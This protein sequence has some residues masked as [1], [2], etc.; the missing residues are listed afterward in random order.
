MSPK[1]KKKQSAE[2]IIVLVL[3]YACGPKKSAKRSHRIFRLRFRMRSR[4]HRRAA[5]VFGV[6]LFDDVSVM[7][8]IFYCEVGR[9]Q[10]RFNH[11]PMATF[12]EA[13]TVS[14]KP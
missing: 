9:S 12:Y 7:C 2:Q 1:I 10:H 4:L 3:C 13:K 14:F 6:T 11:M 5:E 8:T